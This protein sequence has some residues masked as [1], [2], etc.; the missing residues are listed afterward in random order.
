MS[1]NL[2]ISIPWRRIAWT[3]IISLPLAAVGAVVWGSTRDLSR[4][5]ARLADRVH[6]VTGREIKTK[7]PISIRIA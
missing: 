3:T 1:E 7:V 6:K 4:Y 5:E 2:A